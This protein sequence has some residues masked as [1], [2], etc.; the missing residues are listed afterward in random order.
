MTGIAVPSHEIKYSDIRGEDYRM[1]RL[2][3]EGDFLSS[4]FLEFPKGAEKATRNSGDIT[5]TMCVLE[6]PIQITIHK[7]SFVINAGGTFMIPRGRFLIIARPPMVESDQNH[8]TLPSPCALSGSDTT[9][10][11]YSLANT[12]EHNAKL[13]YVNDKRVET[14]P[15]DLPEN[16]GCVFQHVLFPRALA[17]SPL[18][19]FK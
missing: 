4:G 2:F 15:E 5:I 1:V 7:T 18:V 14:Q 10:N 6:G 3:N 17:A 9:G 12:G 19:A 16:G 11:F 8:L 13:F